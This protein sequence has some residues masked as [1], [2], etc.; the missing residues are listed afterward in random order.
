MNS[1]IGSADPLGRAALLVATAAVVAIFSIAIPGSV[2]PGYARSERPSLDTPGRDPQDPRL[3]EPALLRELRL[4]PDLGGHV[5]HGDGDV[6]DLAPRV[7]HRDQAAL[8]NDLAGLGDRD[9]P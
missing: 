2:W 9:V 4:Q 3:L 7:A 1:V 6:G 8:E 5:L